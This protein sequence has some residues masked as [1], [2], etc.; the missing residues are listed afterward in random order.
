MTLTDSMCQEN[1]EEQD[2][3]VLKIGLMNQFNYLKTT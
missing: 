3:P 1:E 2:L